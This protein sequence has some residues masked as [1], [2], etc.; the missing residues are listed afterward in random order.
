MS[1]ISEVLQ[2]ALAWQNWH[3]SAQRIRLF[4]VHSERYGHAYCAL[5]AFENQLQL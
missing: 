3:V 4:G 2:I 1:C 5:A